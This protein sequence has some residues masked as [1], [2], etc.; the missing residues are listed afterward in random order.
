[1]KLGYKHGYH[2]PKCPTCGKYMHN[3]IEG[4]SDLIWTF[5]CCDTYWEVTYVKKGRK[6]V[7]E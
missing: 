4:R 5:V 6:Y 3:P 2:V 7:I 1:M